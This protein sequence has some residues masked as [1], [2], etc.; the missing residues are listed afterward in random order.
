MKKFAKIAGVLSGM[1]GAGVIVA[2][3]NS[4]TSGSSSPVYASV[5][6]PT[7]TYASKFALYTSVAG[8]T[9]VLTEIDTGSDFLMV[10][11]SYVGPNIVMT[12]ESIT[13]VYQHGTNPRSGY[14][15]YTSVSLLNGESGTPIVST[16]NLVPVIVVADG[17]VNSESDENHAIMGVR[18]NSN[19][20]PKL[21]LPYP[22]NQSFVLNVPQSQ[23]IFG[24]FTESQLAAFGTVNLQES[25]CASYPQVSNP[26][27]G[28]TCW[29]DMAIPVNYEI[30]GAP[31]SSIQY[32]SLFDSGADS[33]FQFSPLPDWMTVDGNGVLQN[34]VSAS[35]MTASG[36]LNIPL[37][38]VIH[39]YDS[40][41]NGGIVN[42]GNNIF[43]SYLV[44][45]NQQ[46]GTIGLQP[47]Q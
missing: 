4:G 26:A 14:I 39:A 11:S 16:S 6:V 5:T 19:V 38:P 47:A 40:N 18:M 45:F 3:C 41:Y 7:T 13:Y 22:Y 23:L 25:A 15:G 8:G 17:V 29:N 10:E 34:S 28:V 44:L 12:N 27:T 46:N 36:R 30:S 24:N 20:S 32:N 43:N 1:I 2:S 9:P 21:F 33:S 31:E 42:V 35:L 37:T